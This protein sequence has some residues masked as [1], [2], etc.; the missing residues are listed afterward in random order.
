MKNIKKK[1][2]IVLNNAKAGALGAGF[3]KWTEENCRLEA[4]KYKTRNTF[5]VNSS[6]AYNAARINKWL[7]DICKHM[8]S[9]CKPPGYWTY[10]NCKEASTKCKNRNEF[11]K[12]FGGGFVVSRKNGWLDIFFPKPVKNDIV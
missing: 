10:D 7:G 9:P 6:G 12:N 5:C 4:L 1:G 2:F 11:Y 3:Q 8:V